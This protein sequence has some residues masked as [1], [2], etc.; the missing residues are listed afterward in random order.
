MKRNSMSDEDM[1]RKIEQMSA[2]SLTREEV[3]TALPE[4]FALLQR[5]I[6]LNLRFAVSAF[7]ISQITSDSLRVIDLLTEA[8]SDQECLAHGLHL[9]NLAIMA[10]LVMSDK[11]NQSDNALKA[12]I[13]MTNTVFALSDVI[14]G[15]KFCQGFIAHLAT[16]VKENQMVKM[17]RSVT[18]LTVFLQD[19][20]YP[21]AYSMLEAM[22]KHCS[23]S[24]TE[25]PKVLVRNAR[26]L[27]ELAKH[28]D[29][30]EEYAD[31]WQEPNTARMTVG[32]ARSY[33]QNR[34]RF[35]LETESTQT[36]ELREYGAEQRKML[37]GLARRASLRV[38]GLFRSKQAS[39]REAAIR[40]WPPTYP[41]SESAQGLSDPSPKVRSAMIRVLQ[42]WCK[43]GETPKVIIDSVAALS[44]DVH[45]DVRRSVAR[46]MMSLRLIEWD[47]AIQLSFMVEDTAED[48]LGK[49]LRQNVVDVLWRV[50]F[51]NGLDKFL[52]RHPKP[53]VVDIL[54]AEWGADRNTWIANGLAHEFALSEDESYL[55]ALQ[56][57]LSR[58]VT[59]D[60]N[61]LT[62]LFHLLFSSDRRMVIGIANVLT[63][64]L[65][66]GQ[67]LPDTVNSGE[68]EANLWKMIL[69]GNSVGVSRACAHLL[70]AL[71]RSAV[72]IQRIKCLLAPEDA[73]EQVNLRQL[74]LCYALSCFFEVNV[75]N[76]ASAIYNTMTKHYVGAPAALK[77][78]ALWIFV[79]LLRGLSSNGNAFPADFVRDSGA[80]YISFLNDILKK[81]LVEDNLKRCLQ[82]LAILAQSAKQQGDMMKLE[83]LT[84]L[85]EL[86]HGK[87]DADPFHVITFLGTLYEAGLLYPADMEFRSTLVAALISNVEGA[88]AASTL[89]KTMDAHQVAAGFLKAKAIV[90]EKTRFASEGVKEEAIQRIESLLNFFQ[91]KGKNVVLRCVLKC[92]ESAYVRRQDGVSYLEFLAVAL[93]RTSPSSSILNEWCVTVVGKTPKNKPDAVLQAISC[94]LA[95]PKHSKNVTIEDTVQRALARKKRDVSQW[96]ADA[97]HD[98][99]EFEQIPPKKRRRGVS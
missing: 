75:G 71:G 12:V 94:W 69:I 62:P 37:Q 14:A 92:M 97:R 72:C 65:N 18:K 63:K 2:R 56:Q 84:D 20:Q 3:D 88:E 60:M 38:I 8:W 7:A 52:L 77:D 45:V 40:N 95:N 26:V 6:P 4:L 44:R 36:G 70:D 25:P 30:C 47:S 61:R 96:L 68:L 33:M 73:T 58:G 81:G 49:S 89:L 74:N 39:V 41:P 67:K 35:H 99:A 28:L 5:T 48:G 78:N 17:L 85:C 46:F 90:L 31:T 91:D 59:V 53:H 27:G 50:P 19:P 93:S 9:N 87:F 34:W 54:F 64:A 24:L 42:A 32:H 43:T 1:K 10:S 13:K 76:A 21:S 82:V 22:I 83:C 15:E 23:T 80:I 66:N 29:M 11:K 57:T 86:A 51:A 16:T 55:Q 79:P 98:L